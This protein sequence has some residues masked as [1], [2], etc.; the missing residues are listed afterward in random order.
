MAIRGLLS[1]D[2]A[3]TGEA[4]ST[5]AFALVTKAAL[6]AWDNGLIFDRPAVEANYTV[7]FVIID[8][9]AD[10]ANTFASYYC[11]MPYNVQLHQDLQGTHCWVA[12]GSCGAGLGDLG[13]SVSTK[14]HGKPGPKISSQ[15]AFRY[16]VYPLEDLLLGNPDSGLPRSR[17]VLGSWLFSSKLAYLASMQDTPYVGYVDG[18]HLPAHGGGIN[19]GAQIERENHRFRGSGQLRAAGKP[20]KKVGRI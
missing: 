13:G 17:A 16:P 19:G 3:L 4:Q 6:L 18:L 15:T 2:P 1:Y 14:N 7:Q 11:K 9:C 20:L 12:E 8:Q 10:K 5:Y